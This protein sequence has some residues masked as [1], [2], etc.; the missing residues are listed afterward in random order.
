MLR[1]GCSWRTLRR[2]G[3]RSSTKALYLSREWDGDTRCRAG[4]GV[5]EGVRFATEGEL[6]KLMPSSAFDANLPR[7]GDEVADAILVGA[8]DPARLGEFISYPIERQEHSSHVRP[9]HRRHSN[10]SMP[11]TMATSTVYSI[12]GAYCSTLAHWAPSIHPRMMNAP[13]QMVLPRTV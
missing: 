7:G 13:F 5:P 10:Q 8:R 1:S 4:T 2:R 3:R 11:P 6:A 9:F 12:I